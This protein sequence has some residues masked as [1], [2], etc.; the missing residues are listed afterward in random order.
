MRT[1][2]TAAAI[3]TLVANI[4]GQEARQT[5]DDLKWG[6]E[7][8][9]LWPVFPGNTYKAQITYQAWREDDLAGD[10]FAGIHMHPMSYREEE[11]DFGNLAL[12]Y[13]Y[14]QFFW[15]GLHLEVYQA[16]GPGWNRNNVEDG[17]D[18]NS[19][20]YEVGLLAGYRWEFIRKEKR[21]N[22]KFSPYLSTQ[23][24]FY[25][26]AWKSNPHPV[27]GSDGE[28]P[29]YVGTLNLGIRF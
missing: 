18:Y 17:K 27:A 3:F 21:R 28:E 6:A 9:I 23:Q 20:D 24:G 22:M 12:T 19:W 26:V 7:I 11:G 14:R 8:N 29:I 25:Y 16:F 13:G 1:L 15:E 5:Q 10:I 4:C 2:M